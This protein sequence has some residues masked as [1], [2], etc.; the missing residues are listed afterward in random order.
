VLDCVG[1]WVLV[2]GECVLKRGS[3]GVWGFIIL[4]FL[5]QLLS[6]LFLLT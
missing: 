4:F 2:Y 6:N 3:M 1:V 5:S